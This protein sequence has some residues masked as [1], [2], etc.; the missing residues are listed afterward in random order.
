MRVVAGRLR[1]TKLRSSRTP[2]FRPTSGRVREALFSILGEEVRDRPF[3]D[4]FAGVGGVGIE[5]LSRGASNAVFAEKEPAQL[6][7]LRANLAAL[8]AGCYS[9][10]LAIDALRA[11]RLLGEKGEGFGVVFADPPY[12]YH[13]FPHLIR[14]V[15]RRGVLLPGGVFVLEH[16]AR[17]AKEPWGES[18][19]F[20]TERYGESAISFFRFPASSA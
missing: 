5:A 4:L 3:L 2:G 17:A 8:P 13:R 6:S 18:A 20:R 7:V 9:S 11:L 12:A 1:G 15:E 10:V 16:A 19:P 14:D